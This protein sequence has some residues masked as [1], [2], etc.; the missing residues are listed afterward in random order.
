MSKWLALC[1][2]LARL[3]ESL[4]RR[5]RIRIQKNAQSEMHSGRCPM[6]LQGCKYNYAGRDRRMRLLKSRT[7]LLMTLK[8][9]RPSFFRSRILGVTLPCTFLFVSE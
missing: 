4:A 2:R 7:S 8:P 9:S 1:V 3:S 6:T 5:R